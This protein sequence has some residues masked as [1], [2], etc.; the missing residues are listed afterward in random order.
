MVTHVSEESLHSAMLH[1]GHPFSGL[2]KQLPLVS[3]HTLESSKIHS[4][5]LF[6]QYF[7]GVQVNFTKSKQKYPNIVET[8]NQSIESATL[9]LDG[10]ASSSV[11][12]YPFLVFIA[13]RQI[14][15]WNEVA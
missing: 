6:L 7:Y 1:V 4:P 15:L 8:I 13:G 12:Q 9:S 14:T 10:S 3:S 5:L 11:R 2:L